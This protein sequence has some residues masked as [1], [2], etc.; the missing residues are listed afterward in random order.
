MHKVLV[1]IQATD[2]DCIP[3]YATPFASGCDARAGITE[4]MVIEPG[5]SA[6]IPTG[7]RVALPEGFEIQV[8]PR[9]GFAAKN[10]VTVLNTPGTIDSDY[11]G[12][13]CVIM[14]NHGKDPFVVTPKMRIAQFVLA[15]VI[16]AE[17]VLQDSLSLTQRGDGKF[18]HTGAN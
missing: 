12:E 2:D 7:V 11:R 4:A 8:R 9:S 16:Q 1:P 5:R 14:I 3:S 15:P 10:Q 6:I 13:I 17:F 18:G